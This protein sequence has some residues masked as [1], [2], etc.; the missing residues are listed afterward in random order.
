MVEPKE[1]TFD[2]MRVSSEEDPTDPFLSQQSPRDQTQA[3]QL[4]G[5]MFVTHFLSAPDRDVCKLTEKTRAPCKNRP[6]ARGDRAH[7]PHKLGDAKMVDH[8]ALSE[9]NESRFAA[10]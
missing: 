10:S 1:K 5:T 7:H 9:D 2:E 3:K 4:A 8:T 6:E